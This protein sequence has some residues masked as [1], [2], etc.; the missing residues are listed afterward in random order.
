MTEP[1]SSQRCQ[2]PAGHAD[3]AMHVLGYLAAGDNGTHR[4]TLIAALLNARDSYPLPP[5]AEAILVRLCETTGDD[6]PAPPW[7]KHRATDDDF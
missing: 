6:L 1:R 4:V 5:A 3:W 2:L 7:A